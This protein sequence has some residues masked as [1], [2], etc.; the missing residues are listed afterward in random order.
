[1]YHKYI[2]DWIMQYKQ[3]QAVFNLFILSIANSI[4]DILNI[5]TRNVHKKRDRKSLST[6]YNVI[7]I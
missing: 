7:M 6:S 3:T 4:Y 2:L 1:M 5:I